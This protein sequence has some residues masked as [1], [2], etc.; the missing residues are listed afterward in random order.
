MVYDFTIRNGLL[1]TRLLYFKPWTRAG[2]YIV[3]MW[4]GYLLYKT[5]GG[6]TFKLPRRVVAACWLISTA[7]ALAVLLGIKSYFDPTYDIPAIGG[8]MYAGLHRFV[9]GLVVAWVIVACTKGYAG[10]VNSFL[11]W[12]LFV[13]LSRLTFCMYLVSYFIQMI[14]HLRLRQP[15]Y[16][17]S[18]T[19]VSAHTYYEQ[20]QTK[21]EF[22]NPKFL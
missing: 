5:A 15:F 10:W 13:P 18:Y 16:Y 1:T 22:R 4:T 20:I 12:S 11:S 7:T 21:I 8:A 3:G 6:T 9:W 2:P 14:L 17:D 19:M